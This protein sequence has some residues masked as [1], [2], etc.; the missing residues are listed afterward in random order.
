MYTY[1]WVYTL[2][3]VLHTESVPVIM[4][5]NIVC[6]FL[7]ING[8]LFEGEKYHSGNIGGLSVLFWRQCGVYTIYIR[9]HI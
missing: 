6:R 5:N 4:F 3:R 1:G 2:A 8:M 9:I 7:S